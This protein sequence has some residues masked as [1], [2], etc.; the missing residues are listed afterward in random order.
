MTPESLYV[1]NSQV[2]DTPPASSVLELVQLMSE[3]PIVSIITSQSIDPLA[4]TLANVI[5]SQGGNRTMIV[6]PNS[7]AAVINYREVKDRQN[8]KAVGYTLDEHSNADKLT[9]LVYTSAPY[10]TK[11]GWDMLT[12]TDLLVVETAFSR[13]I[14][15]DML[16]YIWSTKWNNGDVVPRLLLVSNLGGTSKFL[17]P[18]ITV[19]VDGI[20]ET[21]PHHDIIYMD[22][23][24][25]DKN[26]Q[27]PLD[28]LNTVIQSFHRAN[29]DF[30]LRPSTIDP[31]STWIAFLPDASSITRCY[32]YLR[33]EEHMEIIRMYNTAM[34]GSEIDKLS[35]PPS[36]RR[37][38]L[39]TSIGETCGILCDMVFDSMR[40][41]T[42]NSASKETA[43]LRAT[44]APTIYRHTTED[45]YKRRHI[46]SRGG[47]ISKENI[48][49]ITLDMIAHNF[50]P[51]E[52]YE[53]VGV[54]NRIV[55]HVRKG[56]E[57]MDLYTY[58][59]GKYT[60]TPIGKFSR[61]MTQL[62]LYTASIFYRWAS[63][64][65]MG[66]TK[67]SLYSGVSLVCMLGY[68]IMDTSISPPPASTLSSDDL[69][70]NLSTYF[71]II[72]GMGTT[73]FPNDSESK[74]KLRKLCSDLGAKTKYVLHVNRRI[75]KTIDAYLKAHKSA[76][77][78]FSDVFCSD[79]RKIIK[80]FESAM[81]NTLKYNHKYTMIPEKKGLYTSVGTDKIVCWRPYSGNTSNMPKHIYV[82]VTEM[83]KTSSGGIVHVTKM[84]WVP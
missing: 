7:L 65:T 3:Q 56:L 14:Y 25:S 59:H 27:G 33:N 82:L 53:K 49:T 62:D 81:M 78:E 24:L 10:I 48:T 38:I 37:L 79:H 80:T 19:H 71:D 17:P 66:G 28:T 40:S 20:E 23:E 30:D 54:D 51:F 52:F 41:D 12:P 73:V 70:I 46:V 63:A 43:A 57:D 2:D 5:A 60:L 26:A 68:P 29:L 1:E 50:V 6:K 47:Y 69:T 67:R 76:A 44:I 83:M 64:A 15:I 84:A 32:D 45:A 9:P 4:L 21:A 13:D 22:G 72:S 36:M 74:T 18:F 55:K 42:N 61:S 35:R 77:N 11:N 34:E 16:L 58:T 8:K 75:S 31:S 39:T